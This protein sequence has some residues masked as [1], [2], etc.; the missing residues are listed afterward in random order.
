[1]L[2][3]RPLR[4]IRAIH[5]AADYLRVPQVRSANLVHKPAVLRGSR[6]FSL[7]QNAMSNAGNVHKTAASGFGTGTNELYDRQEDTT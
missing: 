2:R 3:L 1:M 5:P 6:T 7:T 4:S